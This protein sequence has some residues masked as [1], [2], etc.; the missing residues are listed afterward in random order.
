VTLFLVA[1]VLGGWNYEGFAED[2]S[3]PVPA[4]NSTPAPAVAFDPLAGR[5][6]PESAPVVEPKK[7]REAAAPLST[8]PASRPSQTIPP[9]PTR[10]RL[11]DSNGQVWEHTD[12]D[13]LRRWVAERNAAHLSAAASSY[14]PLLPAT[15]GRCASGAC[16]RTR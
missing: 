1:A 4:S 6:S 14:R 2:P 10:W 11:A 16:Y 5:K 8:A 15:T 12:P 13:F 3:S 7:P 9:A